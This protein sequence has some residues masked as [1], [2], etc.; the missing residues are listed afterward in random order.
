VRGLF[1]CKEGVSFQV[2]E[3]IKGYRWINMPRYKNDR[4]NI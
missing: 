2:V 3:I 1:F 4:V